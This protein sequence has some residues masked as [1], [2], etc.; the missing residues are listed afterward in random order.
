MSSMMPVL[1]LS[2]VCALAVDLTSPEEAL[3]FLDRFQAGLP[4]RVHTIHGAFAARDA[5]QMAAALTSLHSHALT[6]GALQLHAITGHALTTVDPDLLRAGSAPMITID[7]RFLRTLAAEA[8][9]FTYAY[10]ALRSNPA[11]LTP[12][13]TG[14]PSAVSL[15]ESGGARR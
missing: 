10:L 9:L 4:H 5:G 6:V 11:L 1:D 12:P 7:H 3:G 15:S 2:T 14:M 8:T 13:R